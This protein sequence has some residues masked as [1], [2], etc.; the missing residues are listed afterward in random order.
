MNVYADDSGEKRLVGTTSSPPDTGP[1]FEA[2]LFGAQ[3]V[4]RET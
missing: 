3:S 4:I 2:P 1:S